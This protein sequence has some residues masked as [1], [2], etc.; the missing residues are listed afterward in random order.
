MT[1]FKKWSL[2]L[3]GSLGTTTSQDFLQVED[4]VS[5]NS[6]DQNTGD[7]DDKAPVNYH[8]A[9]AIKI[10]A[11]RQAVLTLRIFIKISLPS[12]SVLY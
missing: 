1:S 8:D 2:L 12:S 3:F 7:D 11:G 6:H 4:F 9:V 5:T 10:R